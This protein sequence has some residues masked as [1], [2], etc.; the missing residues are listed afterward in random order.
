MSAEDLLA[1]NS[2]R[3]SLPEDPRHQNYLLETAFPFPSKT[4]CLSPSFHLDPT[5][6]PQKLC[7][8]FTPIFRRHGL[9]NLWVCL[10]AEGPKEGCRPSRTCTGKSGKQLEAERIVVGTNP[11]ARTTPIRLL[12]EAKA[13]TAFLRRA[14]VYSQPCQR[15][16]AGQRVSRQAGS[17][18]EQ[19]PERRGNIS[20]SQSQIPRSPHRQSEPL[21]GT[22]SPRGSPRA[23]SQGIR[24]GGHPAG[25][26]RQW[27][28]WWGWEG[29][30]PYQAALLCGLWGRLQHESC[31]RGAQGGPWGS[32]VFCLRATQPPAHFIQFLKI[33]A[34]AQSA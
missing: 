26:E 18:A 15:S 1:L 13:S 28:E 20:V 8:V 33:I 25:Q 5:D 29:R 3:P 10:G 4:F 19:G 2:T 24:K 30:R 22:A 21:R 23:Q 32:S 16:R 17:R 14:R 12:V 31:R 7:S 9:P 11:P 6:L 34:S 27:E